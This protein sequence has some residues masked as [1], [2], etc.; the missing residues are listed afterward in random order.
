MTTTKWR[1]WYLPVKICY[2]WIATNDVIIIVCDTR[3]CFR[4]ILVELF[5][6]NKDES[7]L[8]QYSWYRFATRSSYILIWCSMLRVWCCWAR[9]RVAQPSCP[10]LLSV[11][12]TTC[13]LHNEINKL[14]HFLNTR[15][16]Y[17][18]C[19]TL[20]EVRHC[21]VWRATRLGR[22]LFRL[23]EGLCLSQPRSLFAPCSGQHGQHWQAWSNAEG[24]LARI[25]LVDQA[26]RWIFPM[27]P[28]VCTRYFSI[29]VYQ[30]GS[31]LLHH[32]ST[33]RLWY[34]QIRKSQHWGHSY[35]SARVGRWTRKNTGGGYVGYWSHLV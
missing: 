13:S 7:M 16:H 31:G 12:R 15:L 11:R 33:T 34:E 4:K 23:G 32:L 29:G 2:V 22:R 5:Q 25:Y 18:S 1:Y 28:N 14:F 8:Q 3:N 35:W 19:L 9:V 26:W 10:L 24:S 27:L 21:R 30:R 17:S 20:L 6:V